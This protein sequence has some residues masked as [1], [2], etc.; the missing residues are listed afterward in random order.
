[1][2]ALALIQEQ[3]ATVDRLLTQVVADLTAE[4]AVWHAEGST[5]NPIA[6][7]YVHIYFGEDRLVQQ[8]GQSRPTIYETGGWRQRLGF[9]PEAPWSALVNVDPDAMRA[10]AADVR[11][12]TTRFLEGLPP[13]ELE[14]E[15]EGPRGR[16]PLAVN[17]SLLLIIHKASHMGEIAALLGS[18]GVRGFPF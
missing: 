8:R 18:Q 10:Y 1:M 3:A 2:D 7:T 14:R 13:A 15:I 5:A 17:M 6:A 16:R 4:Q 11:A 9:D 12:A